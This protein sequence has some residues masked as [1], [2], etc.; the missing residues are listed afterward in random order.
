MATRRGSIV[1]PTVLTVAA[2]QERASDWVLGWE[3]F[4]RKLISDI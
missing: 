3:A 1:R 4:G 2:R